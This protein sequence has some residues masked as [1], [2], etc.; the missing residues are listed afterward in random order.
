MPIKRACVYGCS[1]DARTCPTHGRKAKERA[2]NH[3]RGSSSQLGYGARWRHFIQWYRDEQ[4]R[5]G[6]PRAGLCG[7]RL[8]GAPITQDSAC[9]RDGIV[10]Y[11]RVVDHIVPVTGPDDPSF[12]DPFAVQLLCDGQAGGNGCHDRKRQ[13]ERK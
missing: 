5:Q 2:Y 4:V 6:V 9:E 3:A 10:C 8:P 12:Y 11:G 1:H 13:R 7:S